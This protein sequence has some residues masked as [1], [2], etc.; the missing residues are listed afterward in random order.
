MQVGRNG[1]HRYNNSDHSM[2]SAMRAVDNVLPGTDHDI[3]AV[4]VESAYHEEQTDADHEQ[5]YRE[6][7][8]TEYVS[9]PLAE[10]APRRRAGARRA[11]APA[12][13]PSR[14]SAGLDV[15]V[16]SSM[17]RRRTKRAPG[18]AG[19]AREHEVAVL[20]AR[21]L[22]ADGQAEPEAALAARPA[23]ALEALEDPVALLLGHAGAARRRP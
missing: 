13:R 12:R 23:A 2:L 21:E 6:V 3:W 15:P 4:N 14:G 11:P 16:G 20:A 7:P 22:A 17:A 1:L 18:L 9:E 8:E 19:R 10:R 5:P